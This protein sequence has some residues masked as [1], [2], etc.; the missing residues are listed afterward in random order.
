VH[1]AVGAALLLLAALVLVGCGTDGLTSEA[2]D[3]S[4]G[5]AIFKQTCGGCHTLREAATRGSNPVQNPSSGPNLDDAFSAS[6]MEGYDESTI[7]EVVRHQIDYPTPPMPDDLLGDSDADAVAVYVSLVAGNP[8]ARIADIGGGGGGGGAGD[9]KS[10]FS[11]NCGS[12]HTL[13]DAGTAGTVGP[14]L[15]QSKPSFEKAVQQIKN[16]G[17]GMPAFDG[18]LTDEQIRALARYVVRVTGG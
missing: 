16:G 2:A 10:L 9:A 12:C 7:R 6:R 5:K 18:Q 8:K 13:S 3:P 15:D 14:N 17:G 1:R 11:T 4:Q